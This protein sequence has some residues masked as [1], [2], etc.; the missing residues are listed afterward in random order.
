[1]CMERAYYVTPKLEVVDL[2]TEDVVRT[3]G[4]IDE[5][6]TDLFGLWRKE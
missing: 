3:S 6:D 5:G 2:E 4:G 1:M